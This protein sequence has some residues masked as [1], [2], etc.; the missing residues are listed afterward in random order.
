LGVGPS[1]GY[2]FQ[3]SQREDFRVAAPTSEDAV[4][5]TPHTLKILV[6]LRTLW[7]RKGAVMAGTLA[8]TLA[9][10][11]YALFAPQ[12]YQ[13]RAVIYPQDVSASADKPA[14]GGLSG[15]LNP[16]QGVGHLNR[17]E[18]LLNS[19]EMA[20]RVIVKNR[21]IPILFPGEWDASRPPT[22]AETSAT[23]IF[24]GIEKI[25]RMVTTKVDVYKMT[26]ELTVQAPSP[27]ISF[28]IAQA[29]LKGLNERSK[30]RVVENAEENRLF[31]EGQMDRT[32]DPSSREKIQDLIISQIETSMLLNANAFEM[33][34]APEQPLY[35]ESPKRK[36][37]VLVALVLGFLV[38]CFGVLALRA[39]RNLQMD[40]KSLPD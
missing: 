32:S 22:E 24:S 33:L 26:L 35:R 17:V 28:K 37:I 3:N 23:M 8:F 38:S 40:L 34:E 13:V 11:G 21:L 20:R 29:Y 30:E 7:K 36:K 15:A 5:E 10:L 27:E 18:I 19:R 2:H 39:W 16:L 6:A 9:G 12:V 25:E 14:F 4:S 1:K 31:L